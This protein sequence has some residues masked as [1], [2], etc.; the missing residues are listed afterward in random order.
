MADLMK[1]DAPALVASFQGDFNLLTEADGS[2][3]MR[4]HLR[5][6]K[7]LAGPFIQSKENRA[8]TTVSPDLQNQNQCRVGSSDPDVTRCT[9][10]CSPA[11]SHWK[12]EPVGP[13]QP[14]AW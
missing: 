3:S 1:A 5:E 12:P 2:R 14:A 7:V 9:R 8:V 4:A 13:G 6:L 10:C 11:L